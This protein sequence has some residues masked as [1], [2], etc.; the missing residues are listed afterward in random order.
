MAIWT[1]SLKRPFFPGPNRGDL[2]SMIDTDKIIRKYYDPDSNLYR[3]LTEHSRY[4]AD[5]ALNIAKKRPDLNPDLVFIEEAALLHDIGIIKTKSVALG[6]H[7]PYPYLCHG[8]LGRE[9][10]EEQGLFPHG[11]VAERHTGTGLSRDVITTLNIG[12]PLRDMIPVT[13]EEQIICYADKFFSKTP[14][15]LGKEKSIDEA[16]KLLSTFSDAH[17]DTFKAWVERFGD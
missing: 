6:C 1:R 11:L 8:F 12:I 3:I 7:G 16:L 13:L 2:L 9:M 14:G 17:V 10:L 4:V 5:K 15:S